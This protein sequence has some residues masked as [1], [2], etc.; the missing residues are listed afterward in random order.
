MANK[1]YTIFEVANFCGVPH[2]N[3]SEWITAGRLNA[4]ETPGGHMRIPLEE[5]ILFM[6]KSCLPIPP[7]ILAK[8]TYM[9]VIDDEQ[10]I[11]MMIRNAFKRLAPHI[12]IKA[13]SNGI[14]ALNMI[15]ENPP[16]LIVMD[17]IMAEMNGIQ[18][19]R[20]LKS[21]PETAGIKVIAISGKELIPEHQ[22]Y[23]A[24]NADCFIKKPFSPEILVRKCQEFMGINI[25]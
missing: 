21:I 8:S 15:E 25:G 17:I 4:H 23:L 6:K 19:C 16:A 7:A 20:R 3:V 22:K 13:L 10:D 12:E 9:M 1:F 5:L 14:E 2:A 24:E 18:V 11:L